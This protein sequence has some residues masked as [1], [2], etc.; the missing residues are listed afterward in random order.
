MKLSSFL[1]ETPTPKKTKFDVS[2]RR[3]ATQVKALT[4]SEVSEKY[5]ILMDK[6]LEIAELTKQ[7]LLLDIELKKIQLQQAQQQ[8]IDK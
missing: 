7:S 5:N 4:T 2:R 3:P 8:N 6:R 1:Q